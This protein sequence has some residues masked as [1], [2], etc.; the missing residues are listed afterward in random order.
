MSGPPGSGNR[1]EVHGRAR[2]SDPYKEGRCHHEA[3]QGLSVP[4][5][6]LCD[7]VHPATLKGKTTPACPARDRLVHAQSLMATRLD[8]QRRVCLPPSRSS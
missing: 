7:R 8:R 6:G 5:L 4:M 2:S 3:C 1:G